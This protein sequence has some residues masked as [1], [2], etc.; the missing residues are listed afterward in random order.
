V[1]LLSGFRVIPTDSARIAI[2]RILSD[3]SVAWTDEGE[4]ISPSDPNADSVVATPRKLAALVYASNELFADS[5]PSAQDMLGANLAR[6]AALK[7]DLGFYEGSG[8]A[9]E[10]RGLKNTSGIQTITAAT[11]GDQLTSLDKFADA[12]GM[13]AEENATASAIVMHPR[14][15]RTLTKVKELTTGSNKPLLQD[16]AGSGSEGIMR[17]IY[18]VPVWQTSQLSITETQGSSSIA[19]SAYVYEGDQVVCVL[20]NDVSLAVDGS[21]GFSS[22]RSAVRVTLRADLVVPNPKA[23][24]RISGLVP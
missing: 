9:P 21:V 16:S 4:E 8:T 1:G 23:V 12:I 6:A 2:P 5:N 17:S 24:V 19:T 11:N 10:I 18:G 22:D 20:R 3:A 14:S 13:L 7:L 15:W